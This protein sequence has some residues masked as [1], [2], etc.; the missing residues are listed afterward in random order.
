[1]DKVLIITYYW[2]PAGGPGVQRWLS[3]VK[4]LGEFGKQA[5]VYIPENPD[6]PM[7]DDSFVCEIPQEITVIKKS[8]I[9]PY[10]W[11]SFFS[12]SK[13]Q[14]ISKG[15]ISTKKQSWIE[16]AMLWVR[17]NFFIP[18]ARVLWV[19]P[20]VNFLKSYIDQHGIKTVI[21]TGPPHSLHLIG[22][23]LKQW[24]TQLNWVADFRD[25][26]TT[27]GYH[28]ELK[29]SKASKKK[30]EDLETSVLQKADKIIT[31]SFTTKK[32]FERK[33]SKPIKVITNG[34][35]NYTSQA[36]ALSPKFSLA[37][38]GS[39]LSGRNPE[40]LWETLSQLCGENSEFSKD[41][42]LILA[43]AVSE[44]VIHSIHCAGLK[45]VL[46]LRGYIGHQQAIAL[47][48]SS[49]VLLLLEIDSDKTRGIIPGKFFE[50]MAAQRP[51]LAMGPKDWDVAR[52]IDQTQTGRFFDY[53]NR[54]QLKLYILECYQSYKT[55]DL[56]VHSKGVEAYHRKELTRT[57]VEFID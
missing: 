43:G 41:L 31:T 50:Y 54:E 32:E 8:I 28:E 4:F 24:N 44:E 7:T 52:L 37:H 1:M 29:L 34:Y 17:G 19:K 53:S 36:K 38:I 23:N 13:T 15:I 49:Q 16:G 11:A 56:V 39:L 27:I 26:W 12:R 42:E 30:H 33:T 2:P 25:P 48:Q 40:V 51:I 35:L 3:F 55:N 6:Y 5:V 21:T 10:K 14:Q 9:E 45:D 22:L 57:L 20:S 18:D 47:Q 46:Q